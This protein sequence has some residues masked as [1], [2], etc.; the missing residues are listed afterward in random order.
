M[1]RA[2]H[3]AGAMGDGGSGTRADGDARQRFLSESELIFHTDAE[4]PPPT[5]AD[6]ALTPKEVRSRW[7]QL[8]VMSKSL[9]ECLSASKAV[10]A[11]RG[12]VTKLA[13]DLAQDIQSVMGELGYN[14]L[15]LPNGF[16]IEKDASVDRSA[17]VGADY[18]RAVLALCKEGV[19]R[20]PNDMTPLILHNT[21]LEYAAKL[22]PR[23]IKVRYKTGGVDLF[24]GD[25]EDDD[26]DDGEGA[27]SAAH[28]HGGESEL[29][30]DTE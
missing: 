17:P 4:T 26:D 2:F 13:G 11:V 22:K 1:L 3:R 25:G 18:T 6:C 23:D 7:E 20:M 12:N 16:H 9:A 5:S 15:F 19:L 21:L 24:F 10:A 14:K 8:R 27:A 28:G 30:D 29:M